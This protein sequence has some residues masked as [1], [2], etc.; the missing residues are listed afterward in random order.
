R[1]KF[2]NQSSKNHSL[3]LCLAGIL[4]C[5]N[6]LPFGELPPFEARSFV[7]ANVNL[8]DWPALAPLFDALESRASA[9]KSAGDLESWL[10]DCSEFAAA[11]D[12]ESARRYIA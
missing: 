9:C 11:L 1:I 5:M 4:A 6:F 7:P 3:L 8:G 2:K 10:R 12:E